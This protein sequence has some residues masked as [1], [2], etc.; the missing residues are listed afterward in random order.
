V[1]KIL[2]VIPGSTGASFE[3]GKS[4]M[5]DKEERQCNNAKTPPCISAWRGFVLLWM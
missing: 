2:Y 5:P 3:Y 4:V 1:R